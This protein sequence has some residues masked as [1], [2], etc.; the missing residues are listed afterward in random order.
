MAAEK[1]ACWE[2]SWTRTTVLIVVM[3][4]S[5]NMSKLIRF[6]T[7]DTLSVFHMFSQLYYNKVVSRKRKI[8]FT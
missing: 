5:K 8:R 2:L 3:M 6:Y 1:Q 4:S 7:A